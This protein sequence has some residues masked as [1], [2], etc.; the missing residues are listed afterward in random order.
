M[1]V[2]GN[3]MTERAYYTRVT[4]KRRGYNKNQHG[5][6]VQAVVTEGKPTEVTVTSVLHRPKWFED[7][8]RRKEQAERAKTG[9]F[10]RNVMQPLRK[11]FGMAAGK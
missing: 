5:G 1:R 7:Q 10:S 11:A 3:Q 6:T 8:V 4:R 2:P 9:W